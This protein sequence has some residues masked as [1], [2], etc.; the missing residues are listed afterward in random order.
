MIPSLSIGPRT[1]LN[2]FHHSATANFWR[3][4]IHILSLITSALQL[5]H[6]SSKSASTTPRSPIWYAFA[7]ASRFR[8]K[9]LGDL[10]RRFSDW[11]QYV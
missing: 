11:C 6:K 2:D 10:P 1:L 8:T 3:S 9:L 7:T 5:L 4:A